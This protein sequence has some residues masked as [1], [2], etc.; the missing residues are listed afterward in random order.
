MPV[1]RSAPLF[2]GNAKLAELKEVTCS[3]KSNGELVVVSDEVLKS[4]GVTTS[5]VSF[6]S[7]V[8]VTGMSIDVFGVMIAQ[9][10]LVITVPFNGVSYNILGSFDE[11]TLKSIVMSGMTTG[12]FKF[13]GGTPIQVPTS[14]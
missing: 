5:E 2:V 7:V 9:A 11:G 3:F 6:E 12:S 4:K 13:T 8:P 1:I 10:D 14:F